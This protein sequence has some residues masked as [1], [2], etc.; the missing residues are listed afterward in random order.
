MALTLASNS[1]NLAKTG[2]RFDGWNT[3]A[4]GS[5]TSYAAG[6]TYTANAAVTL[7]AKWTE[8]GAY[9][10]IDLSG[11]T[12][13]SSYPV[14]YLSAMPSGGWTDEYKTTKLVM[15]KIPK[16]SFTMGSPSGE[17]GQLSD[18]TQ[19]TVTLTKDFYIGVF[20]VT[21]RQWELVMGNRPSYFNNATYYATRPVEQVSYY[22]IR[23]NPANHNDP[24]VDWPVNSAVNAASFM[25][26]L[27]AKTGLSTF[28]LPTE[29]QWEYAC[30]AGTT[31][32]LN[33]GKNL[34]STISCSNMSEV[35]R[36]KYNGGS[37][38]SQGCSPSAGTALAGSYLPN[39][40]GLYD[41][42]GNVC[43]WCLDWY[44]TYPGT[45]TDPLGA[46]S[47]SAGT[48]V[49][50]GG[51]WNY[52]A[53]I[54]RSA[55][56]YYGRYP[57]Y[58]NDG[59]SGFRAART[60]PNPYYVVNGADATPVGVT[61]AVNSD[62]AHSGDGLNSLK[63]GG[64]GLL[65]DGQMAGIEWSATGPGILGFD[66]KVSSEQDYDVLSFYEA[67][68]GETNLISGAG[69]G[70]AHVSI[71]VLGDAETSHTFR[72]EYE[73]DPE[74]D[75]VGDDAGWVDAITWTPKYYLAVETGNGDGWYTNNS[76]VAIS[77]DEPATHYEFDRWTGGTNGVADIFSASTTLIMPS[78]NVALVATYKPI[79]Y[80]LT[81]VN[82]S[83]SGGHAYG[84]LVGISA[85]DFAGKQFYRW[86]GD[87][88]FVTSTASATTTVT[89]PDI[90]ISIAATYFVS[91]TVNDGSGSGWH[92]EGS[93]VTVTADPDPLYME[94]AG[95]T[96][97]AAAFLEDASSPA[98]ILTVPTA[99]STLTA[100]YRASIARVSGSYGRTY[101]Q[102]GTENGISTDAAAG[103]PSGNAAVKLGGT[104]VVPDN[105]FAAFETIVQC[106]GSITSWWKSSS[107]VNDHL[108]F[109]VDDVQVSAI[110]GTK[111]LWTWFSNR[112]EGAGVEHT[113]RWE[114]VKN[115]SAASSTDAGW[116]DDI[117]WIADSDYPD[118]KV[119]PAI[120]RAARAGQ[121]MAIEFMGER[122]VEYHLQTNSS[123]S[124]SGWGYFSSLTPSW[125]TESNGLHRFEITPA[126]G[127][128]NAMFYRVVAAAPR[129]LYMSID[130]SGGTGVSSYPVTYLSAVPSGGW[131]DEHKTTKLVLRR[132][133]KG[134]DPLGRYTLTKD[135]Y[136]GVF[137]V[138][139]KQWYLV[140]GGSTSSDTYP[141]NY[142]SYND[143]RGSS[144]GANWPSSSSVDSTSFIGRLR[145]KTGLNELDLP[146]EAQREYA[147]RAG[148]TTTYN[149]GDSESALASA[150]WYSGNSGY[151]AHPAGQ[152]T[153]NAWGLYDMHG[154]V[155]EWCLDWYGGSLSGNDP[156]GAASGSG[157]H[158]R[159][160]SFDFDASH[161][162]SSY[163]SYGNPSSAYD[164]GGFRLFRTIP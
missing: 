159:G 136:A 137:E 109:L 21:Q 37:G 147:C 97:D 31:T 62:D 71:E 54:A 123:L 155:W 57:D 33:S 133:P 78:T 66:W 103:A 72:W 130:L 154:N 75:Y 50:R 34:T 110:S 77:A 74:G 82:G 8:P 161:A 29:S 26:K 67:G 105:G 121:T 163:R 19:H 15:R 146:T 86:T 104:G 63:L 157:R 118:P 1:G 139:Q 156:V 14:T 127:Q 41:M 111:T 70:W 69:Q 138:T 116:V 152:K 46:A 88:E 30:R 145:A 129:P 125:L 144:S 49:I 10:V 12:G 95:W 53:Y 55:H 80:P 93:A 36:Y 59:S 143:I 81:V 92:P 20:E 17:L 149:T 47:G 48:R 11:G 9:L 99:V 56:R 107:E 84:G 40:W 24:A 150:G 79:L 134:T 98:T 91:L 13:A 120:V 141:K 114:Y 132:C 106:S 94:F 131:T 96:G 142:V 7:Y 76:P 113:L 25:G 61:T 124:A 60:L 43:E 68:V 32:A 140:M 151:S 122:G 3:T 4:D 117:I 52:D 126:V 5:G 162:T 58:R 87:V 65:A 6:G 135:F 128:E 85:S 18:E 119:T 44:G 160:G 27:R 22:D 39:A 23:E 112:V 108:R 73:K 28:D 51:S 45:V 89:M 38:S 2:Y 153:A 115:G 148:T 83:G 16:G 100:T 164:Y 158:S 64:V 35:G 42:H 90:P 102:S 101:T